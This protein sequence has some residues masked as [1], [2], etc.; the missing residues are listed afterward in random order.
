[1]VRKVIYITGSAIIGVIA[2]LSVM[3]TLIGT[4]AIKVD[5]T[6]LVISSQSAEAVYSG[7][8]LTAG[9][10]ELVDGELR[11]GHTLKVVVSGSQTTAGVS[12]NSISA[13]VTDK[14]GADVTDHYDI[15]YQP[16]TLTV[17]QRALEITAG[18]DSKVYDGTPLTL[19]AY[20]ITAG[21]LVEGHTLS[22]VINGTITDVGIARN[23][24]A[25]SI[26]D[27][28]GT[29]VTSSYAINAVSGTLTVTKRPLDLQSDS[30]YKMYDGTALEGSEAKI[31]SGSVA[32]GHTIVYH[33]TSSIT[34]AGDE[35]NK[36]TVEILDADGINRIGNYSITYHYGILTVLPVPITIST[37]GGTKV[38][39][40]KP[41]TNDKWEIIHGELVGNDRLDV[42]LD[43]SV[44]FEGSV[45]NIPKIAVYNEYGDDV[46]QNYDFLSSTYGRL[47]VTKNAFTITSASSTRLYDATPLQNKSYTLAEGYTLPEGHQIIPTFTASIT[48]AG[49]VKNAFTIIIVNAEGVD[50]TANFTPKL[51][52]GELT[53]VARPITIVVDGA[54]KV[55]DGTA[56]TCDKWSISSSSVLVGNDYAELVFTKSRTEVGST[57][58][59][60]EVKIYNEH[61][62][63]VTKNYAC[64][65]VVGDLVVTKNRFTVT[66]ASDVKVYDATPLTNPDYSIVHGNI[67]PEG[68]TVKVDVSGSAVNAGEEE[69]VFE[70]TV[71]NAD[72]IDVSANF[73]IT[74]NNGTLTVLK[75]NL[76]VATDSATKVYDGKPMKCERWSMLEGSTAGNDTITATFPE[77]I[78]NVGSKENTPIFTVT[79]EFEIDVTDNYSFSVIEGTL[80]VTKNVLTVISASDQKTYDA[81]PLT[82]HDYSVSEG[83]ILPDGHEIIPSYTASITNAG[84]VKNYFTVTVV[85]ADGRDVTPNFDVEYVYGLL[86]VAPVNIIIATDGAEK[87]YDGTALRTEGWHIVSG[88]T[89]GLD[90]IVAE[91]PAERINV[92]STDNIPVII[93]LNENDRDVTSNYTFTV[94]PGELIVNKC[95]V[96]IESVGAQKEYDATPLTHHVLNESYVL[97]TGHTLAPS[98]TGSVTNAETKPNRFTVRISNGKGDDVTANFDIEYV[99]GSLTVTPLEINVVTGSKEKIY[100]GTPLSH[101]EY[102]IVEP[103]LDPRY[104]VTMDSEITDVGSVDNVPQIK[105]YSASGTE[106]TSNYKFIVSAGKLTVSPRPITVTSESFSKV[107][108]GSALTSEPGR[109]S[110]SSPLFDTPLVDGHT[111]ALDFTSSQTEAGWAYNDFDIRITDGS[112]DVTGNY[113][114]TKHRGTLTVI[115][116]RVVITTKSVV[117]EY[118]GEEH[119]CHDYSVDS[120]T[121][122]PDGYEITSVVFSSNATVRDVDKVK[123][124]IAD[125]VIEKDGVDKTQNFEIVYAL[126]YVSVTP[127]V[128]TIRTS[129]GSKVYDG[130]PLTNDAWEV[131]SITKPLEHHEII[132]AVSGTRTEIGESKNEIAEIII[133]DT[134]DNGREVTHNYEIQMQLGALTVKA[135]DGPG[136]GGSDEP[137][138]G[139]GP[140]G[141]PNGDLRGSGNKPS[142]A[143]CFEIY[144]EVSG[145]V[146]LRQKSFGDF[147]FQGW[148]EATQYSRLLD[149]KYSYNYLSSIAI[150]NSGVSAKPM[151]I[152]SKLTSSYYLPYFLEMSERRYVVPSSDVLYTGDGADEYSLYYLPYN[153]NGSDIM[154]MLGEYSDEEEAYYGFVWDNYRAL[155][156]DTRACMDGIIAE[157]GFDKSQP[158]II[159]RVATYIR[160]IAKYNMDYN[161]GLDESENAIVDFLT[162]YNQGVCRHYAS[163]ATALFR[164]LDI[165]ARYTV[166]FAAETE[167]FKWVKV[168]DAQAHA[169]VEVYV[170]GVGWL[171]VEV[172]GSNS[173]DTPTPPDD[174]EEK[175]PL[176]ITVRP[177]TVYHAYDGRTAYANDAKLSGLADLL[178]R[179]YTYEA[180][181]SGSRMSPGKSETRI[182]SFTLYDPNN[183]DVTS[184]FKIKYETGTLHVYLSELTVRTYSSERVYDGTGLTNERIDIS[185]TLL[186]GHTVATLKCTGMQT[187]VGKSSNGFEIVI[188]DSQGKDVTDHYKINK[189][190]GTLSITARAIHVTAKSAEKD[191]DDTPLVLDEY[192]LSGTLADGDTLYVKIVGSQTNPGY[193]LNKIQSISIK[194]RAG[195]DVTSNYKIT[196]TNGQLT[197]NW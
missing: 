125:L 136:D 4:G 37:G 128:I 17:T 93:V 47:I 43:A 5:Q 14:N 157:Q 55:Y 6:K 118:D 178:E 169:W 85:N 36:F 91:F 153:G 51:V 152:R 108:D 94:Q 97:P 96:V 68:Y 79:D 150:K 159:A 69:N 174:T 168:T 11:E 44:T 147:A 132:V 106:A 124:E 193:S 77:E 123:N 175:D 137:D 171:P 59:T 21:E 8:P 105:V 54:T 26:L 194:N 16:G 187:D 165:P 42:V 10:W 190:L 80:T 102:T 179:G 64:T 121:P 167:A 7:E 189:N 154:G 120:A 197:V 86:T 41:L 76:V 177:Q 75:R 72:G 9:A 48:N 151:T 50:V 73:D 163:A 70:V 114:I 110:I 112:R 23:A 74:K 98:F 149:G 103:L 126:G 63:D 40:G 141:N 39:D 101:Y 145:T 143:L 185:G 35:D 56:L 81:T 172:T 148:E 191:Y 100:D 3:F 117:F 155:D 84:E 134:Q 27:A 66:S 181:I 142:G 33:S 99:Y 32:D 176:K 116:R 15:E 122:L 88:V 166:G 83:Y 146:Y 144:S 12:P 188:I 1:M 87:T 138:V 45:D 82:K 127:R 135:P 22:P 30:T 119:C 29:D 164:A 170:K 160:N 60:P 113:I 90:R 89:V 130:T 186:D 24:I 192:E 195:V 71:R 61:A 53:V 65:L 38:Y 58:N 49:T 2:L 161:P 104:E 133:T 184:Q 13:T 19:N 140:G 78:T 92:G 31:V 196:Q 183:N 46:T 34:N 156:D 57:K 182:E 129:D 158:D 95:H 139:D 67:F 115:K 109:Y 180:V 131:V 111:E 20:T 28:S 18:S 25:A 62:I 107:Y 52:Q 162:V 173:D